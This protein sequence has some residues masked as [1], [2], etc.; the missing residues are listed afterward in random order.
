MNGSRGSNRG[1]DWGMS[2]CRRRGK[3]EAGILA[4][5]WGM[6]LDRGRGMDKNRGNDND[7]K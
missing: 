3:N 7:R 2:C 4:G 6:G 1:G 5:G